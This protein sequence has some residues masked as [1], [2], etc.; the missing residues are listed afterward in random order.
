[1]HGRRAAGWWAVRLTATLVL[2][3]IV[4]PLYAY[5]EASWDP[6]VRRANVAVADWPKGE[7]PVTVLLVS[8]THVAG[9][10]MPPD[11]LARIVDQLN[12][13]KPDLVLLAGDYIGHKYTSTTAYAPGAA[14]APLGRFKAPLG[15][16]AVLGNHDV[17]TSPLAFA[18]ALHAQHITLLTKQAVRRGP[19]IIGGTDEGFAEGFAAEPTLKAMNALGPGPKILLTH[20][21]NVARS[22]RQ[23]IAAVLAGHTHC[24][25]IVLP[26]YGSIG[27]DKGMLRWLP[28]GR[29]DL[30]SGPLFVTAGVGTSILPLR[31]G[32]RPDVWLIRFG[33]AR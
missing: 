26:F 17:W 24:G 22:L 19:L 27:R 9:P 25:Q 21:P 3:L 28:C 10:D 29:V 30:K 12:G 33:P 20:V 32:A 4:L 11:R 18:D 8:D 7:K 15:T 6:V 1:V 16:I 23:P 13:L 5:W 2:L 31:L 14:I